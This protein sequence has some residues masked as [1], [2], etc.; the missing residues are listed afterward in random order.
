[1][2]K[3]RILTALV[4]LPLMLAALFGFPTLQWQGFSALVCGLALWE[5]AR[6][7]GFSPRD[8]ALYLIISALLAGLI[9]WRHWEMPVAM[10]GLVLVFWLLLVPLWL[11]RRWALPKGLAAGVLGWLLMF[12]AWFAMVNWRA[13]ADLAHGRQLLAI[14]ALVWVADVAAYFAGKAFGRHKLA[15]AI[16]PGKSREGVLGALVAVALFAVWVG[17]AGWMLLPLSSLGLLLLA[18]PLT[19]VSV[20]GDLLESWFKRGAGMKDSSALLPGHGGVYD[21]IDSLVAVL[22][23]S[24]ALRVLAGW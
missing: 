7:A 9:G 13:V 15:P 17:Q 11:R 19:L 21:R 23:V 22:A 2:L 4:L 5:F 10:H 8:N 3:T 16:S 1:M 12:P 6:M 24:N 20:C 14:M 18:L